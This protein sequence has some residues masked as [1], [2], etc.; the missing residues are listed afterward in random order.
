MKTVKFISL[1]SCF[2]LLF[3]CGTTGGNNNSGTGSNPGSGEEVPNEEPVDGE[4]QAVEDLTGY[5]VSLSDEGQTR[6]LVTGQH[7][8]SGGS[9]TSA[10]MYTLEES[11]KVEDSEGETL[12][13]A[14]LKVGMKVT[15]WN[16]GIVAESFPAQSGAIKVVVDAEQDE[17]EQQAVSKALEEVEAG[18]PWH[19]E[20]VTEQ[21]EQSYKVTLKNL[22]DDSEPVDIE[23]EVEEG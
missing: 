1:L 16:S 8:S 11:T 10:T 15:V 6:M 7:P 20:E 22:L 5:I 23:V 14:D 13:A 21:G 4:E 9:G 18:N 12:E 2:L 3:G 17:H 19:V